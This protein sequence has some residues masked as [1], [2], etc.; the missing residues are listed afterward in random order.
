VHVWVV[1]DPDEMRTLLDWGVSGLIS[2]RPDLAVAVRDTY[3]PSMSR[4]V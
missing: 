3:R 4:A 2:D 1:D